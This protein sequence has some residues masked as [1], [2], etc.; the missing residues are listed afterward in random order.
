MS[1]TATAT[2]TTATVSSSFIERHRAA[3]VD[4]MKSAYIKQ[5]NKWSGSS[6]TY[7]PSSLSLEEKKNELDRQQTYQREAAEASSQI[8]TWAA[9]IARREKDPNNDLGLNGWRIEGTADWRNPAL[10]EKAIPASYFTSLGSFSHA[11][12]M[13]RKAEHRAKLAAMTPVEQAAYHA[14]NNAE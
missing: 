5:S 9:E 1:S 3:L 10:V 8:A 6:C 13:K 14:E 11:Q 12:D 4:E 7:I 2:A